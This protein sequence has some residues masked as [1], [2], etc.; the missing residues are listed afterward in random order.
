MNTSPTYQSTI[1]IHLLINAFYLGGKKQPKRT[2]VPVGQIFVATFNNDA[3][4]QDGYPEVYLAG[5]S[6]TVRKG[7]KSK[8]CQIVVLTEFPGD[9]RFIL[10]QPLVGISLSSE[11]LA[12][13]SFMLC[14]RL[15]DPIKVL[16]RAGGKWLTE[17]D[18]ESLDNDFN[19]FFYHRLIEIQ[20]D[21]LGLWSAEQREVSNRIFKSLKD[22]MD[23]WGLQADT[24]SVVRRYPV[25]LT[26]I[27]LELA[28]VEQYI[29]D[30]P[31]EDRSRLIQDLGLRPEARLALEAASTQKERPRGLWLVNIVRNGTEAM[32][33][34]IVKLLESQAAPSAARSI[35]EL[36][37]SGH[38]DQEVKLSEQVLIAALRNPML[39]LGEYLETGSEI[40]GSSHSQLLQTEFLANINLA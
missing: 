13:V 30:L 18:R 33:Q 15:Y 31:P 26:E 35:Q 16:Q 37:T 39:C 32:R 27:V 19:S 36:Y 28:R 7:Q 21:R 11:D 10:R 40:S 9:I 2:S 34:G 12:S 3:F 4:D 29:A 38:E 1:K 20:Q 14:L 17:A 8:Q 24:L 23:R 22:D 25:L 5:E 6:I